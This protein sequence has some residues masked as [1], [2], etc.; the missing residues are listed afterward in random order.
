MLF[1]C[2][3]WRVLVV[4]LYITMLVL[5]SGTTTFWSGCLLNH[6]FW[7][8]LTFRLRGGIRLPERYL[9]GH[10]AEKTASPSG[11]VTGCHG[12]CLCGTFSLKDLQRQEFKKCTMNLG[13]AIRQKQN[14]HRE[15]SIHPISALLLSFLHFWIMME[16]LSPLGGEPSQGER[17]VWLAC[18]AFWRSE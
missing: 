16:G 8:H 4:F 18:G 13:V 6:D 15:L 3:C 1:A 2:A 9:S 10:P 12:V 11:Q 17:R 5:S 7:W 14:K